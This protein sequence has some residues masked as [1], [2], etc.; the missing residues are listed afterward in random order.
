MTKLERLKG[1]RDF[2]PAEKIIRNNIV[3]ALRKT[4]ERY[5]YNPLETPAVEK[6]TTLTSKESAGT[7]A[8]KEIYKLKDLR[9]RKLGLRF[10]LTV[11]MCRVLA[12]NLQIPKPFK[13]YQLGRAWRD[14]PTKVGRYKEF[15]QC[16][17][18]IAGA[19]S[20]YADA[21]VLAI[22]TDV[23]RALG[24]KV[25][26]KINNRKLINGVLKYS[27]LPK[28]KWM[29]AVMSLDKLAKIGRDEVV[30]DARERGIDEDYMVKIL[31]ILEQEGSNAALLKRI[32]DLVSNDEARDGLQEIK[33]MLRFAS[34]M[35]A[36][37]VQFSPSLAR[38]LAYYT[39]P[40]FEVFLKSGK[41]K[42]SLAAG[43]RYDGLVK[44]LSK[45]E[46]DLP[47][48]GAS[49]GL[50]TIYDALMVEKKLARRPS[51]VRAFVVPIAPF[52][53]SG[54]GKETEAVQ[55]DSLRIVKELRAAGINADVDMVGRA[56]SR[57]FNYVDNQG[58]PYAIVVGQ[59]ELAKGKVT[60]KDMVAG[61]E[62]LVTV[63]QAIQLL[64]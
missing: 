38:G 60:L 6:L 7:D 24:L 21:E 45:G 23:F 30:D 54:G 2:L 36:K 32:S 57:N 63:A 15:W 3:D 52:R 41:F 34:K 33:D 47:A 58:I 29:G 37:N 61:K 14:G 18:D 49:F 17:F 48:T 62:R 12:T 13:R 39:G 22:F 46:V 26:I 5:G 9:G 55:L 59:R 11:P 64:K 27:G 43:G 42:S 44:T 8:Y 4:F 50:D 51:V 53:K 16:D 25:V 19:K 40:V 20:I 31:D 1:T 35:G 56:P 10:D 28:A